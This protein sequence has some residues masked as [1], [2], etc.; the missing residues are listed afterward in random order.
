MAGLGE[1]WGCVACCVETIYNLDRASLDVL[2][3]EGDEALG[4]GEG[5]DELGADDEHLGGEAL[6]EGAEA[7][8]FDHVLDD[9]HAA[10]LGFEV[11]VLDARLYDVEGGSDGDGCDGTAD[12]SKEV[13]RPCSVVVVL[14][15]KDV[16]LCEGGST[17]ERKG[18]G[19][20]TCSG[21]APTTVEVDVLVGKNAQESSRS[22][23]L[24]VGLTLD[25]EHIQRQQDDLAD[26]RERTSSG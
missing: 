26:T 7:L 3:K 15:A 18:A 19:G 13:L 23:G 12:G 14:E 21:P 25:L 6:E 9:G 4:D 24:R 20:V 11:G 1:W 10:D 17:E 5:E 22:E 16:F 2:A 8:V